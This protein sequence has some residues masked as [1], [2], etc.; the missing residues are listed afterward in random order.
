MCSLKNNDNMKKGCLFLF[1][2]ACLYSVFPNSD[3][4][5]RQLSKKNVPVEYL[6]EWDFVKHFKDNIYSLSFY[7]DSLPYVSGIDSMFVFHVDKGG[8]CMYYNCSLLKN[9]GFIIYGDSRKKYVHIIKTGLIIS[10]DVFYVNNRLFMRLI[11]EDDVFPFGTP[12]VTK[13]NFFLVSFENDTISQVSVLSN[14]SALLDDTKIALKDNLSYPEITIDGYVNELPVNFVITIS[15]E[16]IMPK[17]INCHTWNGTSIINQ[18][19]F[20]SEVFHYNTE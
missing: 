12:I 4:T 6:L 16:F 15:D 20:L 17:Q 10:M 9:T 18:S 2:L 19:T 5:N 1:F 11:D 8:F 14:A 13:T 3:T 7:E